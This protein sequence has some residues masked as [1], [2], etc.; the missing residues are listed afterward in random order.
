MPLI[1]RLPKRGFTHVK[2]NPFQIVNLEAL[3]RFSAGSVVDPAEL[4]KAGLIR[5]GEGRVKI[6]GGGALSHS[7]TV[8]AHSFSESARTKIAESGGK[9][10]QI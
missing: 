10:E 2:R 1:R 4:F 7:L 5:S 3:N 6:L 8:K 9:P